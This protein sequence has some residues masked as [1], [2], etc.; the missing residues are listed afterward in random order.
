MPPDF[1]TKEAEIYYEMIL[2]LKKDVFFSG[3]KY[4]E[5]GEISQKSSYLALF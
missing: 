5:R 3:P 2:Y 1:Q 4:G